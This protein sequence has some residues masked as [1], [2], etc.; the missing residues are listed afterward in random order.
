MKKTSQEEL[1]SF[2]C[3]PNIVSVIKSRGWRWAGHIA[4]MEYARN[5]FKML[6]GKPRG[7]DKDWRTIL[8][9]SIDFKVMF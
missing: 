8:E 9:W 1:H 4:T 6:V 3:S 7:L 5:A 2:Y